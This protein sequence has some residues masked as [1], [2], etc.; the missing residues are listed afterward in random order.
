MTSADECISVS[1][2]TFIDDFDLYSNMYRTL[3]SVYLIIAVFTFRER[4]RRFNV[5][6][7]TLD[8]H[9]S[10]FSDVV[11][12]FS[13]MKNLDSDISISI[14]DKKIFLCVFILAYLDDMSQQQKNSEFLSYDAHYD[15]RFCFVHK[16]QR[17][18]LEFDIIQHDWFHHE[19]MRMWKKM[20]QM[21]SSQ[22]DKYCTFTELNSE[23]SLTAISS[24]LDIILTRSSDS[25]HTEYDDIVKL[26]HMSL[27]N[28][29]LIKT[30]SIEYELQ[31]RAF[32]FSS[33]WAW[34]QSSLHH[35]SSYSFQEHARWS[36]IIF[37]LL[38][39]W[40]MKSHVQSKYYQAIETVFKNIIDEQITELD[41]IITS[42][43][44]IAKTNTL[45]MTDNLFT[46][47]RIDFQIAVKHS[48]WLF[49]QLHETASLAMSASQNVS[50]TASSSSSSQRSFIIESMHKSE[51]M[52]T[53][54]KAALTIKKLSTNDFENI[55]KRSNVHM[56]CH[57]ELALNEYDMCSNCN[58]LIEEDKHW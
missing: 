55:C 3:M 20:N 58:V 44:V 41:L 9:E 39:F 53:A 57:H 22:R 42:F 28:T 17:V 14:N 25:V 43:A 37:N 54:V 48:R 2:L 46:Q 47:D 34:L 32:L 52:K 4:A 11:D 51:S 30:F 40:L 24:A 12:A 29:I 49:Q 36:V 23:I 21:N 8:S 15:C 19:S 16:D 6:S 26:L 18:D 33:D 10:N 35:L 27:I 31:L 5:L 38:R 13:S 56:N 7:L 50:R 1:L 45:L